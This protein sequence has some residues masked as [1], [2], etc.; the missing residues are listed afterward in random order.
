MI[1]F[2]FVRSTNNQSAIQSA[3]MAG[4]K[5]LAGGT[6]LV[7][8]MKLDVERPKRVVDINPLSFNF[9]ETLPGGGIKIGAL[10][11]NSA[12]AYHPDII[13]NYPIISEAI[14]SGASPQLRN[15]ASAGGNLLQRTRCYYFYDVS[16]ACN[17]RNPGS[18]C[19]AIGGYN[20]NHAILGTSDSCIATHPSD[21]CVALV[22]LDASIHT[23]N[24]KGKRK[25]SL[26]DFYKIPGQTPQHE[27]VLE[28]GELI[29][30]IEIPPLPF[31]QRSH[32]LKV[33][34]RAS[35]EFALASAG[36]ILDI[37]NGKIQQAR[38]ALGGVGT[39]PWRSVEAEQR[40][41]G[42]AP[43]KENFRHAAEAAFK[44]AKAQKYNAF[45]IE[46]GKRTLIRSL[47]TTSQLV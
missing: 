1:T 17:K 13:K 8:L 28:P 3:S 29:T 6:N 9:I 16:F 26:V 24:G 45:K 20:R 44:D 41:I 21:F 11:K 2:D 12:I 5:F 30:S 25:I 31:S 23:E 43:G 19:S 27:N 47:T 22:A 10:V 32:Y 4:S 35:Y 37:S 18:G 34:D 36:V 46:L 33:R 15:M 39:K 38:V 42:V 40:L 7:D 14:L